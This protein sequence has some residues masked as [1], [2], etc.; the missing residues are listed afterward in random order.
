MTVLTSTFDGL[1]HQ[2][3]D[4]L[5]VADA[6]ELYSYE[7]LLES[8][9]TFASQFRDWARTALAGPAAFDR[10]RVVIYAANS[11]R[12]IMAYIGLLQAGAVPFLMD[13]VLG[14]SEREH[15]ILGC[16]IDAFVHDRELPGN[17]LTEHVRELFGFRLSRVR[18]STPDA[19]D[20]AGAPAQMLA[21]TEVCRFTSGSTGFPS[22]LEFSGNAVLSAA[23]TWHAA[24]DLGQDDRI[25]CFAG[26]FNGLAFN[27]SLLAAFL[28][29]AALFVPSGLPSSGQAIRF[30][31]EIRPSRLVGFPFLYESLLRRAEAIPELAELRVALSSAAPLKDE[32]L[33]ALKDRHGLAVCNYYGIAETGPLTFDPHPAVERGIGYP[34]PG[35]EFSFGD[36]QAV[37]GI[38][39]VRSK[40]M[41]SRYLNAP[42][43]LE[44]RMDGDRFYVTGDEGRLDEGRLFLTGRAGKEINLAGRKI[45]VGELSKVLSECGASESAVFTVQKRN[46]D[47]M[48]VAVVVGAG[49]LTEDTIRAWCRSRLA[50]YKVPERVL[51]VSNFPTTSLGKPRMSAIRALFSAAVK[52]D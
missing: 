21:T 32:T 23:Q 13:P 15:I 3:A 39:R 8:T 17:V 31:R 34:L 28:A 35:V 19:P 24:T 40:S 42:A 22:C 29:G 30:L 7:E 5:A 33:Q 36:P 27:T 41:A 1:L 11:A 16:G 45:D 12:Y 18:V 14:A 37:S 49:A 25:L 38:I 43:V 48:L 46:G 10:P 4:R 2:H 47:P 6:R 44:S 20:M 51:V 26:L 9:S 50:P 52:H